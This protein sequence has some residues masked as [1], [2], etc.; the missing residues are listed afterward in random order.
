MTESET[1]PD[2]TG[3]DE[4][5]APAAGGALGRGVAVIRALLEAPD[6]AAMARALVAPDVRD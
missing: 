6:P 5:A 2:S 3:V 1:T 4:A